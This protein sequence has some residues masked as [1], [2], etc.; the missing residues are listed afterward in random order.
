MFISRSSTVCPWVKQQHSL[1]VWR[2]GEPSLTTSYGSFSRCSKNTPS[3]FLE[4]SH[5]S[6]NGIGKID[7]W[8]HSRSLQIPGFQKG[9]QL[10]L[11]AVGKKYI[12]CALMHNA[13]TC[14][15]GN[16]TVSYFDLK[17]VA[18]EDCFV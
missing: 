8:R 13:R 9:T 3:K 16:E 15:Y 18:I 11:S 17:P 14:M 5:Q 10:Q 6:I 2:S 7:F 12:V 1:F 4:Q